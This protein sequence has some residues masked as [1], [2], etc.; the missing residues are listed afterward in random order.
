MNS[1][2]IWMIAIACAAGALPA[3]VAHSAQTVVRSLGPSAREYP[4]GTSLPDDA[5]LRLGAGDIVMILGPRGTRTF[6]GPGSFQV[7]APVAPQ[8][9]AQALRPARARNRVGAV[10]ASG[11]SRAASLWDVDVSRGG[12]VCIADAAN[13]SLWRRDPARPANLT[14][15]S[16]DG[17]TAGVEFEAGRNTQRW[18]VGVPVRAGSRYSVTGI[19]EAR[20]PVN[21]VLISTAPTDPQELAVLFIRNGCAAQLD[22]LL[23]QTPEE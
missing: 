10:R 2:R 5:T 8:S 9:I 16:D 20:I 13:V 1:A 4:P 15:V 7:N 3:T 19:A 18:P 12:S 14:I 22:R 6:R 23:A 17:A 21:F 11:R